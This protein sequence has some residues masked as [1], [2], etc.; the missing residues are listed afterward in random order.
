M[1]AH[2]LHARLIALNVPDYLYSFGGL[3]GGEIYG[4]ELR[5]EGWCVYFSER[6]EKRSAKF[7][8]TEEDAVHYFATHIQ[9]LNYHHEGR[10][11]VLL[12]E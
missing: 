11:L 4:I 1:K 10:R 12:D 2:E 3:G 6:G 9:G 5:D 7:F 8:A